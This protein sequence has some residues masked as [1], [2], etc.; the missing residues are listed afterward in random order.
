MTDA[1]LVLRLSPWR[2]ARRA[3]RSGDRPRA[4]VG[5]PSGWDATVEQL[6]R[7]LDASG[8]GQAAALK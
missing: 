1:C 3:G 8:G 7:A 6:S 5:H 2:L 4:T